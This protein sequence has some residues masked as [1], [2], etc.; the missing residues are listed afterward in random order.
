MHE[1]TSSGILAFLS[2]SALGIRIGKKG[3]AWSF[4]LPED[5]KCLIDEFMVWKVLLGE[6]SGT[7][8]GCEADSLRA[9]M[10]VVSMTVHDAGNKFMICLFFNIS[11]FIDSCLLLYKLMGIIMSRLRTDS[12]ALRPALCGLCSLLCVVIIGLLCWLGHNVFELRP[13]PFYL[14]ELVADLECIS[15]SEHSFIGPTRSIVPLSH[16]PSCD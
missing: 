9:F 16:P 14:A 4:A 13:Q 5:M 3:K 2:V 6:G 7:R 11:T 15:V 8:T 12:Y 10:S 1:Y